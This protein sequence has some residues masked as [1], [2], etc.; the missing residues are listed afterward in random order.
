MSSASPPTSQDKG[1]LWVTI[2]AALGRFDAA[3]A[4]PVLTDAKGL[5]ATGGTDD[6]VYAAN[7]A[8]ASSPP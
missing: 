2:N 5:V 4:D 1:A 7:Q 6:V 8:Q 3:P